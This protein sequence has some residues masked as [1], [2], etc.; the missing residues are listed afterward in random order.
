MRHPWAEGL[1]EEKHELEA[2][3]V[4]QEEH[5]RGLVATLQAAQDGEDDEAYDGT[6][7]FRSAAAQKDLARAQETIGRVNARFS[8]VVV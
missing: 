3:A 6:P 2:R 5:I 8:A 4:S 7:A 1:E